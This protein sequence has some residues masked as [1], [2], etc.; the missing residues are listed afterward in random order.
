[1]RV[2][3]IN[4]AADSSGAGGI[5]IDIAQ[6]YASAGNEVA[7]AYGRYGL[8]APAAQPF[9]RRICSSLGVRLHGV[10]SLLF[11]AHGLGSVQSTK[12][13][14]AWAEMWKPDLV[15]LHNLHGYYVNYEL[16]FAWIKRHPEMEVRWT[17]HDCWAFT[18]HCSH[19][20]AV[21]C[22][23]WKTGCHTCPERKRYPRSLLLDR[24]ADNYRRKKAAFTGVKNMT[25]ITPSQ[26]LADQL[27]MSF[28]AEYPVEVH[29]NTI[30]REIFKP[31][32]SDFRER[33]GLV[34]K[35]IVL[36]VAFNWNMRKGFEDFMALSAMLYDP[37]RIVLVGLQD[38]QLRFLPKNV[39]GLPRT[40]SPQE[41]A[42]I[43]TAADVF[44]NTTYEDNYPT[45]NLEARACGTPVIT[46]NTGG[47]PESAGP[48]AVIVPCGDVAA[49]A[50]SIRQMLEEGLSVI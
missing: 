47:S 44:V 43:Y 4:A 45:V 35:K 10:Q 29:Y 50:R 49:L 2:L 36:G 12:R 3:L 5:C 15:W 31:T 16:L 18:G 21:G 6:K 22:E 14:L 37:Y 32:P 23:Q 11:D 1:M 28:L 34:G 25:L 19:Y 48:D 9:A 27:A 38:K 33:H 24:C 7:I 8:V 30:N 20:M 42:E 17:L 46:Y 41:L 26:W 39:L 13:F 40:D